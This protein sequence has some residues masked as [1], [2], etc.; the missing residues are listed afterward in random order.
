MHALN[1]VL[2]N[3]RNICQFFFVSN[4]A[5]LVANRSLPVAILVGITC[6]IEDVVMACIAVARTLLCLKNASDT[7]SMKTI[8]F[9]I[10]RDSR[11]YRA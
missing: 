5:T 9:Y 1:S 2:T 11:V 3:N 8:C 4:C 7:V 10:L 6:C